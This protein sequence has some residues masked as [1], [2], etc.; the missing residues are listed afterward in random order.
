MVRFGEKKIGAN[1]MIWVLKGKVVTH[2]GSAGLKI[3]VGYRIISD[4]F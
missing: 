1:L 4:L 3:T 2:F